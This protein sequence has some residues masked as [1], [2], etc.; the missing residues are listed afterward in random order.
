MAKWKTLGISVKKES[1]IEGGKE[2]AELTKKFFELV[3]QGKIE[4][5]KKDSKF[6]D[7]KDVCW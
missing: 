4:E 7:W 1:T 3:A 2:F 6:L 5:C